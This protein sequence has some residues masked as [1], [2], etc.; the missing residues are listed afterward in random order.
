MK[1]YSAVLLLAMVLMAVVF[2]E[3]ATVKKYAPYELDDQVKEDSGIQ[4]AEAVDN[5]RV[6]KCKQSVYSRAIWHRL[7]SVLP[8]LIRLVRG[9]T[10]R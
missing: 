5:T 1:V 9:M 6:C 2:T 3:S 4:T 7:F 8:R 10:S